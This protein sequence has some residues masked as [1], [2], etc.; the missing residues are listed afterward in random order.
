M[1]R[2]VYMQESRLL[3]KS[4][5]QLIELEKYVATVDNSNVSHKIYVRIVKQMEDIEKTF[6]KY[7]KLNEYIV[8]TA[9]HAFDEYERDRYNTIKR[10]RSKYERRVAMEASGIV[11]GKRLQREM[12]DMFDEFIRI[13]E[14]ITRHIAYAKQCHNNMHIAK[15]ICHSHPNSC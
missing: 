11:F 13:K 1:E 3:R 9:N 15:C 2:K 10:I 5:K 4:Y 7:E 14:R 12:I 8:I 6:E